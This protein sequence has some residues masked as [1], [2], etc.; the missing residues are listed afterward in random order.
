MDAVIGSETFWSPAGSSGL[1][2]GDSTVPSGC[3]VQAKTRKPNGRPGSEPGL[4]PPTG[5]LASPPS[6]GKRPNAWVIRWSI[7]AVRSSVAK[8]MTVAVIPA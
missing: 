8:V 4:K 2:S 5:G 6:R 1:T 3:T 7:C